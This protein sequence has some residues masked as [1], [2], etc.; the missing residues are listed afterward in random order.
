MRAKQ[1]TK[2]IWACLNAS[3]SD[4]SAHGSRGDDSRSRTSETLGITGPHETWGLGVH[5]YRSEPCFDP[6]RRLAC[7]IS[8]AGTNE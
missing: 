3:H 7:P 6:E 8:A 5:Q 2:R 1:H 4:A